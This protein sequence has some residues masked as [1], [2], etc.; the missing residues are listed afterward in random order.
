MP[1]FGEAVN[2]V[3]LPRRAF[4]KSSLDCQA[5]KWDIP[6]PGP[7]NWLLLNLPGPGML[8][9]P[10]N[11]GIRGH[12]NTRSAIME[13]IASFVSQINPAAFV[14]VLL[15]LLGIL[16]LYYVLLVRSILEMLRVNAH[17]VLLVFAFL[18]LIPV[19]F[20]LIMGIMILIIWHF[21]RKTL[22]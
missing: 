15:I 6:F 3:M 13:S 12:M 1:V 18:S 5:L 20:V 21:H 17:S 10:L 8:L 4:T 19:P 16:V 11:H 2:S 14:V 22:S 7:N 9:R